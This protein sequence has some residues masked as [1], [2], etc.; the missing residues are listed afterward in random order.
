MKKNVECFVLVR[1]D[2][3]AL[4]YFPIHVYIGILCVDKRSLDSVVLGSSAS[5]SRPIFLLQLY[6]VAYKGHS[7]LRPCPRN[8]YFHPRKCNSPRVQPSHSTHSCNFCTQES[9][10]EIS[11]KYRIYSITASFRTLPRIQPWGSINIYIIT[12]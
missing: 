5:Y 12:Y 7:P 2:I 3:L 8:P 1:K 9:R 11:V 4:H 10:S 6:M